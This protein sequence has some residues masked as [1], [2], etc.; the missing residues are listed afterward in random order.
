MFMLIFAAAFT[1]AMEAE[2]S[3]EE[4]VISKN[5]YFS[6]TRSLVTAKRQV[7]V[8]ENFKNKGAKDDEKTYFFEPLAYI[9]GTQLKVTSLGNFVIVQAALVMWDDPLKVALAKKLFELRKIGESPDSVESQLL[10]LPCD[11]LDVSLVE[12]AYWQLAL[13]NITGGSSAK[14]SIPSADSTHKFFG[15][16]PL[17]VVMLPIRIDFAKN[18][19]VDDAT[20]ESVRAALMAKANLLMLTVRMSF[21][22]KTFS[23]NTIVIKGSN[24]LRSD[25][26]E[27]LNGLPPGESAVH[28]HRDELRDML[29]TAATNALVQVFREH[30]DAQ[31]G[32]KVTELVERMM[33]NFA[34]NRVQWTAGLSRTLVNADDYRP[35]VI[36]NQLDKSTVDV[37][38]E[39][40]VR[41]IDKHTEE[42]GGKASG[43]YLGF[44]LGGE[45]STKS[46]TEH[47]VE[48]AKKLLKKHDIDASWNGKKWTVHNVW[49][50]RVAKDSFRSEFE[51][52]SEDIIVTSQH[53]A[54]TEKIALGPG[55]STSS[56]SA[57]GACMPGTV[58]AYMGAV[59]P[60]TLTGINSPLPPYWRLADGSILLSAVYPD[61]FSAIGNMYGGSAANGTFALPDLRGEFLR[62]ASPDSGQEPR[63]SEEN[64]DYAY[65]E[66]EKARALASI[67]RLVGTKEGAQAGSDATRWRNFGYFCAA[68][69]PFGFMCNGPTGSGSVRAFSAELDDTPDMYWLPK[70]PKETHPRNIAV[71]YIVCVGVRALTNE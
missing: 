15:G 21:F 31:I 38:G 18:H 62:G 39:T 34:T 35:D 4:Y 17:N 69:V 55:V 50:R 51:W 11:H 56:S 23:T 42:S 68:Q 13:S 14:V 59:D 71:N 43:S 57:P 60:P 37:Q 41:I 2:G 6:V 67:P 58:M 44:K 5:V 32:N 65:W 48:D 3:E 25:L 9:D 64:E 16:A 36:E 20:A 53:K 33:S 70:L 66:K 24:I 54:L 49:L 40:K 61:I 7:K 52:L 10:A 46:S 8:Y 1:A 63:F 27:T 45:Y 12:P 47:D 19:V 22:A 28:V 30:D 29:D 26:R